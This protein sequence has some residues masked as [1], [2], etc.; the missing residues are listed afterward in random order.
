MGT[1]YY[2]E[3]G[4]SKGSFRGRVERETEGWGRD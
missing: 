2:R 1:E 3:G 4:V